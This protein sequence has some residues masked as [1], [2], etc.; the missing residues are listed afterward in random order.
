MECGVSECDREA[1]I[2]RRPW[3]T[4]GCCSMGRKFVWKYEIIIF[5][6]CFVYDYKHIVLDFKACRARDTIA[7]PIIVAGTAMFKG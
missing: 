2:M 6:F 5:L 1:S 4:R 3:P 7:K